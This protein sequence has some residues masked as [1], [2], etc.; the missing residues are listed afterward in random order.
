M[1]MPPSPLTALIP[2]APS[3]PV[4]EST[5]QIASFLLVFG[6]GSEKEIYRESEYPAPNSTVPEG[7]AFHLE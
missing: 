6:Q 1:A 4:P 7:V 2:N 5:M 3:V